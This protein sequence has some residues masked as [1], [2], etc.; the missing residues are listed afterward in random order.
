MQSKVRRMSSSAMLAVLALV[1]ATA[2]GQTGDLVRVWDVKDAS[3]AGQLTIYNA[4]DQG[5]LLGE[6]VGSGDV[7][8]D[9]YDDVVTCAF[10][11]PSGPANG[12][13]GAGKAHVWFGGPDVLRGGVVDDAGAPA[14][15]TV[16]I[17]GARADDFLGTEVAVADVSGDGVDDILLCAENSSGFGASGVRDHAGALYIIE[18]RAGLEGPIDLASPPAGVHQVLGARSGDRFGFWVVA[19]DVT[20]DGVSDVVVSADLAKSSSGAGNARGAVYL[21]PGGSSLPDRIDLA[22]AAT[23]RNLGITTIYGVDDFDHLGSSLTTGDFDG[24]GLV[25]V[26]IGA[27]VSRAGAAFSG[28]G[29]PNNALGQGGGDGPG[30]DREDAGEVYVVFGRAQWPSTIQLASPPPDVTIVYGDQAHAYFGEDVRAGDVDGDGRDELA[31]GALLGDAPGRNGAG[32]GYVFWSAQFGRGKRIDARTASAAAMTTIYGQAAGDIGADSILL[33]DL[34]GDGFADVLFGSPLNTPLPARQGA[35]DLKVIYGGPDRL[36]GIVD[37]ARPAPVTIYQLYAADP[38]DMFTYSLTVGDVDGDG[39]LDIV[40][41][42]MGGDGLDNR[43]D[44]AGDAFV[45]S[46]RVFAGRT[47]RGPDAPSCLSRVTVSPDQKTYYAGQSGI[48]L[49]LVCDSSAFVDGAVA[50]V[51]G[52]E[53]PTEYVSG[54]ELRVR[55]DDAPDVRNAPGQLTVQ[56]RNPGLGPSTAVLSITLVGPTVKKAKITQA[57]A[58]YTITVKGKT[59][60][61]GA[62]ASVTDASGAA[63]PV[64][65]VERRSTKKLVVQIARDAVVR[66]TTLTVVVENP[67][68]APSNAATVTVP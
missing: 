46:G 19:G 23:V 36:P 12:R 14:S 63:V 20:G 43:H 27:G 55:L 65:T 64:L 26:A 47:G 28:Y 7:D 44:A 50:V 17:W 57:N 61:E 67:G 34:D 40:P 16:E 62:T 49:T 8:G 3:Q 54:S 4:D 5:S 13:R 45:I 9:G 56:V 59:F 29:L 30:N 24:D 42:S 25:D 58:A 6:P 41:N 10:Y 52:V 68:P 48:V 18:G 1:A 51:R 2:R 53:V 15:R 33:A 37:T 32:L 60:L 11:G 39:M 38:A 31:V 66:G 35:G 21:I 22:D